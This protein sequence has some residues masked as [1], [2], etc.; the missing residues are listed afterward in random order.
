MDVVFFGFYGRGPNMALQAPFVRRILEQHPNVRWEIWNLARNQLD[1]VNLQTLHASPRINVL[2]DF[3]RNRAYDA[4]YYH[5]AQPEYADTLFVKCDDDIVF[6]QTERFGEFLD[7]IAA[8]PGTVISPLIINNGASTRH[9][10]GLWRAYKTL[11]IE[12]L[13]VHTDVRFAD[14]CHNYFFT[15]WQK[16]LATP[17]KLIKTTDWVSINM[18]GFDHP[19]MRALAAPLRRPAPPMIAGRE[20]DPLI[21]TIGDEGSA[22]LLP[23]KILK[24]FTVAHLGFGPQQ[25]SIEQ[26]DTW[27]AG[28][29][30]V[31][32][33]YL[34]HQLVVA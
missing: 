19:A 18:I 34:Q 11:D 15:H 24:G 27:R 9:E 25:P 14:M 31:G 3:W 6:I 4:V 1:A 21:H 20:F 33:D 32:A 2:N 26:L 5:Y 10:P 22:N 29:A 7:A 23:R 8:N 12:L 30:T 13:Q 17:P 16:I 28:Y